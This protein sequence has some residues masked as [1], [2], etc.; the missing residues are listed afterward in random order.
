MRDIK[1]SIIM[2]SYTLVVMHIL[3][4]LI[5][6]S[7]ESQAIKLRLNLAIIEEPAL[8]LR[9]QSHSAIPVLRP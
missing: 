9:L 5:I 6:V 1:S 3:T 2:L 7:S 8:V 4:A